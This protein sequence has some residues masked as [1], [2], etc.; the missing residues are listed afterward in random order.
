LL[1]NIKD[2][3]PSRITDVNELPATLLVLLNAFEKQHKAI[4]EL[5]RDNAALETG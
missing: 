5:R 3:D 2:T 1:S 4:E